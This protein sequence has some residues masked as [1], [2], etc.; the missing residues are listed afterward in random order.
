MA[1]SKAPLFDALSFNQSFWSKALSHP[2]RITI[3][4]HLLHHG[5]TPFYVIAKK[6]PLAKTTTSQHFRNLRQAGLIE[7]FAKYPHTYYKL[8]H[9][10]CKDL[11]QKLIGLH[12]SFSEDVS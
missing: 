6:I 5:V 4:D 7:S 11:A 12:N 3:L 2:A 9:K 1:Y 8:N 10:T